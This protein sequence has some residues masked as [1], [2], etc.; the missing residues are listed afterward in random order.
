MNMR[1]LPNYLVFGV[2]PYLVLAVVLMGS[3]L[4]FTGEQHFSWSEAGPLLRRQQ[5]TWA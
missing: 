4:R 3:W 5:L 1:D 2:Y